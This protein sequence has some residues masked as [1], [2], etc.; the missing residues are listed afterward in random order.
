MTFSL[1]KERFSQKTFYFQER[2]Y[3]FVIPLIKRLKT[4]DIEYK[5]SKNYIYEEKLLFTHSYL[6][7][8]YVVWS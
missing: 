3:I 2:F 5:N 1:K 4:K 7:N 8:S 6:V